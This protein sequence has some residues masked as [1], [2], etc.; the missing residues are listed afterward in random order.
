MAKSRKILFKVG[1]IVAIPLESDMFNLNFKPGYYAYGRFYKD[2]VLGIYQKITLGM[3]QSLHD[4]AGTPAAFHYLTQDHA[5]Y[6]GAWPII[7]HH[8]FPTLKDSIAPPVATCYIKE[9]NIWTMGGPKIEYDG[10][11]HDATEAQVK[12]MDIASVPDNEYL[13]LII[14]DRLIR[15]NHQAYQVTL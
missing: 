9:R 10:A 7:G 15:G 1:D 12:G 14:V 3:V 8:A 4:I 6:S 5:I 13:K 11:M 2:E